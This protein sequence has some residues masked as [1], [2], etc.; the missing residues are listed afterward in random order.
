MVE[1][2]ER[3]RVILVGVFEVIGRVWG[4][5]WNWDFEKLRDGGVVGGW[6]ESLV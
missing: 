5:L 4:F 1:L 3:E 6:V 2:G